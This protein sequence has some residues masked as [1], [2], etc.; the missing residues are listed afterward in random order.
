MPAKPTARRVPYAEKLK[1]PRWQK[2]RLEVLNNAG[3]ICQ[4]CGDDKAELQVHHPKYIR[5]REPWDYTNL[6]SLCVTCHGKHHGTAEAK[7]YVDPF[8]RLVS[9]DARNGNPHA[10]A[11][12]S[13]VTGFTGRTQ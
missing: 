13:R 3:W 9:H 5:G 4:L 7:P 6:I 2:K 10:R 11:L 12:L 8:A 1:D